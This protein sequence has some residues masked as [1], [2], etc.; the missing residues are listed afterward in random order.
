MVHLARHAP[1]GPESRAVVEIP[2]PA[3][4][5]PSGRASREP[6]I[7]QL[8]LATAA[9]WSRLVLSGTVLVAGG[10]VVGLPGLPVPV[11]LAIAGVG[12]MAGVPHGAADHAIAT[13]MTGGRPMVLVVAVYAGVTA[14]VWALL[15]WAGPAAVIP[16]VA[17]GALHFGLGELEVTRR[18]TGWRPPTLVA[19]AI[20]VAGSGAL[21]LPLA[22]CG[23][24]LRAVATTVS[25]GLAQALA[26]VPVQTG[27]VVIWLL[28]ALV[29][30][31][32]ALRS[33]RLG[34]VLDTVILGAVG[35]LA[36]PLL[37]F[38][39]WF[40]GWH[41]L[42][43]WARM[44]TIEPGCAALLTAG[45]RREAALRLIRLAA[46][47][48]LAAWTGFAAI[49]WFTA[50]APNPTAVVA[51]GLRLLLALTVPHVLV[52]LWADRNTDRKDIT[53]HKGQFRATWFPRRH[54][55]SLLDQHIEGH[56]T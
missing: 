18:L 43:H 26:W 46:M 33:A 56:A 7:G 11:V 23:D 25:P 10:H 37:A 4:T 35:M 28:A 14:A 50:T 19:G 17:L 31:I 16:V 1:A 45:R 24:Q 34:V 39:V 44:L 55:S 21:V 54:P 8:P 2:V 6:T 36:P 40:G 49:G 32:A 42:R 27:L 5:G 22:R 53:G 20:A 29:A 9:T 47:P 52:V 3:G 38:A 15:R 51:E 30:V 41:S 13:H 48:S 12:L